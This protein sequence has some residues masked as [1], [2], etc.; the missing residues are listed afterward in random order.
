MKSVIPFTKELEFSTKV[1][2]ITSISL[3]REFALSNGNVDGYLY[4]TGEYKS[5]EVSVNVIPFSFKIPFTIAV[6]EEVKEESVSLEIS[7]FAYD[8]LK[9]SKI[10]VHIELEL[11]FE[12]KEKE[13]EVE[14]NLPDESDNII[15][16]LE[17]RHEKELEEENEEIEIEEEKIEEDSEEDDLKEETKQEEKSIEEPK[18]DLICNEENDMIEEFLPSTLEEDFETLKELL[19][20]QMKI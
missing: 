15:A 7:D 12:E 13:E 11:N 8:M 2:E 1:S 3:E 9:D 19:L 14:P 6:G 10:K 20:L 5:H 16:M 17:E 18:D 4:V